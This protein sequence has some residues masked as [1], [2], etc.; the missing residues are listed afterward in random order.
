MEAGIFATHT[1]FIVKTLPKCSGIFP[2][3][4]LDLWVIKSIEESLLGNIVDCIEKIS[5]T[6]RSVE[7][8]VELGCDGSV[9]ASD[10]DVCGSNHGCLSFVEWVHE[11]NR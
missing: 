5:N 2:N 3:N 8:N 1:G 6:R 9:L 11:T 10:L 7:S 4:I